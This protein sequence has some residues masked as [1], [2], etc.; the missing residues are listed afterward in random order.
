M[1]RT[2]KQPRKASASSV[3]M[4]LLAAASGFAMVGAV[5]G[6]SAQSVEGAA[7]SGGVTT[8]G[9]PVS[10]DVFGPAAQ[11]GGLQPIG[12]GPA[13]RQGTGSVIN[14]LGSPSI[15]A[16]VRRGRW[17]TSV[18]P[19]VEGTAT[20][21]DNINLVSDDEEE[22]T[23]LS[24]TAGVTLGAQNERIAGQLS[25]AATY[26]TFLNNTNDD[27]FRH[28]LNTSWSAAV[29]P[30][31]LHLDAQ[32]GITEIFNTTDRFSGN[33]VANSD[34]R[35]RAFFG[36]ISPSLRKNIGGWANAEVRYTLR[37]ET[38]D[39]DQ[40]GGFSQ[41]VSAG[42]TGDPRKFRR[43]GWQASTEYEVFTPEDDDTNDDLTRWTSSVSIDVPVSP[44]L[45]V[46]ATAGYDF[47]SDDVADDDLSGAFANAGLRWQPT[48]RFGARAFG[49]WRYDGLDYGVEANY[50]LRQNVVARLQ[51]RRGVQFSN[52]A[53]NSATPISTIGADGRPAF[54]TPNGGT[55]TN[56]ND[57]L[58]FDNLNPQNQGAFGDINRSDQDDDSIVDTLQA[59]IAGQTGRT[60]WSA[61]VQA[62]DFD[63][64][65]AFGVDEFV[66][67]ANA[68]VS[69][70]LTS[71]LTASA[72]VGFATVQFD[73]AAPGTTFDDGDFETLSLG[74]GL[75][76]QL[77]EIVNVF[78]R[79]TYT[80]RFA[81][82][83]EDEFTENAGV[84]G[85]TA[86][87]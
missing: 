6:L 30:N 37:G 67:S 11:A 21:S 17:V 43:F 81:D 41:Q 62:A 5:T 53:L 10:D 48:T 22:E 60:S 27:G 57:A 38:F 25:Y 86:R 46:I 64:G 79:Y 24:A 4:G 72:G 18:T 87:F 19:F 69:R 42:L 59:S 26:D 58:A 28:N 40:D 44:K 2:T 7:Q 55:T 31:L 80:E 76:Y 15:G 16:P 32:G 71:R 34:D 77:T 3:R 63:R 39:D 54:V 23:I 70:Q 49:G 83:P 56:V 73:D 8:A 35:S 52:F 9:I 51:A 14:S 50:A 74:I 68:D 78:G 12:V 65:S 85:V 36:L 1:K 84:I 82:L 13:A 75:D 45:A 47:F 61:N 33:S 29:I 66:L 20:Y